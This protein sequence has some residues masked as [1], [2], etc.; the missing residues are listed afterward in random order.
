MSGGCL[1]F[2]NHQ[3]KCWI[4]PSQNCEAMQLEGLAPPGEKIHESSLKKY[5]IHQGA[6]LLLCEVL[7]NPGKFGPETVLPLWSQNLQL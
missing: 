5:L 4:F 1:G 2:L 3:L 7:G 6:F